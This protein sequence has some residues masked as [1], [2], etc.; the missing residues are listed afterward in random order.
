[1]SK[2]FL[3]YGPFVLAILTCSASCH[4]QPAASGELPSDSPQDEKGVFGEKTDLTIGAGSTRA[5]R[6]PG[7]DRFQ[8]TP[9]PVLS[10]QRGILFA[11]SLRGIG[12]QYQSS[13]KFYISQSFF[14]DLGRIE[15]NNAWRPGSAR[16]VGMG[17]V[18]G[19]STARTLIAQQVTPWLLVSGETEM[20]LRST[21]RRN[22]YR[23]GLEFEL[24]KNHADTVTF[25]LDGWWGDG[26]YNNS[27]FGVTRLQASR[28]G[29]SFFDPGPGFYA[30]AP[31]LSWEH[32]FGAHW[33]ATALL[34]ETRYGGRI[35]ASPV[36]FERNSASTTVFVAYTF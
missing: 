12:L 22:R 17:E 34:T 29:F 19:S 20:A 25:D 21:A 28:T 18:S 23:I 35:S 11:D 30:Q 13:S 9:A 6:Y 33:T 32:H 27:Y 2:K 8:F 26:R 1:M 14:Y 15:N 5:P 16:L 31:A 24:L 4:A 3:R 10:I 36:V 7:G